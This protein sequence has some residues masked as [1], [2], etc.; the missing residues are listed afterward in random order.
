MSIETRSHSLTDARDVNVQLCVFAGAV[1]RGMPPW[2]G[3]PQLRIK[4]TLAVAAAE[5]QATMILILQLAMPGVTFTLA[6]L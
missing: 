3:N 4:S 2:G 1:A 5:D 6:D